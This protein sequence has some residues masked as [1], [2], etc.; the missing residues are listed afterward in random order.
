MSACD[1]MTV[2]T[3]ER[4]TSASVAGPAGTIEKN[5]FSAVAG[6]REDER[7]L[8]EVAE[9]QRGHRER[10]PR[11][12]DGAGA[13]VPHVRVQRLAAG[14]GKDD[15]AQDEEAGH[16]VRREEVD[17]VMRRERRED[18]RASERSDRRRGRRW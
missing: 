12:A 15:R 8:A 2:A 7:A 6:S 18:L 10:E 4:P 9:H 17:G 3:L 16:S 1:A 11:H 5:G 13:E 14:D